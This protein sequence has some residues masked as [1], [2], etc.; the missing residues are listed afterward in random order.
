MYQD[1]WGG[2][3]YILQEHSR[4]SRLHGIAEVLNRG[5]PWGDSTGYP[6]IRGCAVYSLQ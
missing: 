6:F 2:A 5:K 4:A 1:D 3:W